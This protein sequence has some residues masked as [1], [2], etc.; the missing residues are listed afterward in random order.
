MFDDESDA[1]L[2]QRWQRGDIA[3]ASIAIQRHE[4]MVYAAV[5]R[6]LHNHAVSEDVCQ[7]A[8]LRAHQRIDSLSATGGI[9]RVAEADSRSH[10]DRR[11]SP[12]NGGALGR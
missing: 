8:F 2:V 6:L 9:P 1:I 3:A 12:Q 11:A 10:G 5:Y 4:A 7:D